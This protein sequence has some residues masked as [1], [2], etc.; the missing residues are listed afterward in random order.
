MNGDRLRHDLAGLAEQVT[1]V[2]LRDRVLRTSRRLGI[3][4]AIATSAAAVVVLAAAAGTAFALTPR[5]VSGPAPAGS[6]PAV[7]IPSSQPTAVLTTTPPA[8]STG[9][10]MAASTAAG[11]P[12]QARVDDNLYPT[13][14]GPYRVGARFAELQSRGLLTDVQTDSVCPGEGGRGLDSFYRPY[15]NF[16]DGRLTFLMIDDPRA[17]TA[18]GAT[19]GMTLAEVK[20]RHPDGRQLTR[21]GHYI[22]LTSEGGYGMSFR[23]DD[24]GRVQM[25]EAGPAETLEFRFT[26]GE[27]C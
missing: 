7:V 2:D 16:F 20:A 25:I 22:W 8:P 3:Q 23:F 4:R 10:S 11:E 12:T 24:R 6:G 18:A 13:G 5:T 1:P 17:H 21:L 9:P 15:L 26:E 14:I 27:G 19:P